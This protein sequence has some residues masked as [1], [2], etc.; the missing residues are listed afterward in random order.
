MAAHHEE[1]IE[2]L[3]RIGPEALRDHLRAGECSVLGLGK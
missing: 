2:G 3:E 1:L